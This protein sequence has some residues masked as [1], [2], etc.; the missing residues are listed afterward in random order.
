MTKNL[1][2][3][4]IT[5]SA[6]IVLWI[7]NPKEYQLK[8]HIK[9]EFKD[10]GHEIGGIAGT[11]EELFSG[12]ASWLMSLSIERKNFYVFS[13]YTVEGL[14]KKHKYIGVLSNFIELPS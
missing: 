4:L 3:T 12:P 8:E 1:L 5:I 10:E 6:L 13:I 11:I 9:T 2:S 7:T 14:E